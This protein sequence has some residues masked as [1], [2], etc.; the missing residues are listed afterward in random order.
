MQECVIIEETDY[1]SADLE[2]ISKS[3]ELLEKSVAIKLP[4][5]VELDDLTS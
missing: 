5:T 1:E 4:S 2:R 3:I